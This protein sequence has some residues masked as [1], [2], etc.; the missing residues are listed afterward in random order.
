MKLT[1][2]SESPLQYGDEVKIQNIESKYAGLIGKIVSTN[3]LSAAVKFK[4]IKKP[5]MVMLSGLERI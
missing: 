3:S 4:D 2:I 5:V 1:E